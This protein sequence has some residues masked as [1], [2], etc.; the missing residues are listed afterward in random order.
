MVLADEDGRT[1]KHM[2]FDELSKRIDHPLVS[3]PKMVCEEVVSQGISRVGLFGT[4]LTMEQDYMK[5]DLISAGVQ[6]K[7]MTKADNNTPLPPVC[8][9]K[10][11]LPKYSH[12]VLHYHGKYYDPE[13]G[14]M[15]ELYCKARI[16]SYLE[17]YEE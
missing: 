17:L 4:V 12:W 15:D 13:F 5:K 16:Q 2:V 7:T 1:A 11:L 6:A 10:V 9:L 8:I 14:L 3:I